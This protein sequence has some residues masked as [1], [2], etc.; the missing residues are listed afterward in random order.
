MQ[1]GHFQV[2]LFL[3]SPPTS[4]FFP[5]TH[6]LYLWLSARSLN[7]PA[8][9]DPRRREISPVCFHPSFVN[10]LSS[11]KRLTFS[12]TEFENSCDID[13][14]ILEIVTNSDTFLIT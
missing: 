1:P 4:P 8:I 6:L 14:S 3:L 5:F 12:P 2:S 13:I 9:N 10:A 7:S 11:R